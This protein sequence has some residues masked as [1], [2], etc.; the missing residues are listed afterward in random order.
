[1]LS[2]GDTMHRGKKWLFAVAITLLIAAPIVEATTVLRLNLEQMVGRAGNIFRATVVDVRGGSIEI[3]GGKL[4]TTT[5]TLRVEESFKG[6]FDKPGATIQITMAGS[7]KRDPVQVGNTHKFAVLPE[8]PRLDIGSDYL[9]MTTTPSRAGL[10]TAVG[11]GQGAFSIFLRNRQEV[12][13]N[14]VDNS[15]IGT[16][17]PM[18]Y[19][20]LAS[21]IR[22]IL[23]R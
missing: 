20:E 9:L 22:A 4:P 16:D 21:K 11:L 18:A 13:V 19:S 10:S 15:N 1:M 5:Y 2:E 14:A 8:V 23:G 12:A 3:G 7:I 17:G 6:S